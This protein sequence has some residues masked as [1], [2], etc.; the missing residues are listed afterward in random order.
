MECDYQVYLYLTSTSI[1]K[2]QAT[3]WGL[4]LGGCVC[5]L[6]DVLIVKLCLCGAPPTSNEN[7]VKKEEVD[8]R[9][10]ARMGTTQTY[11]RV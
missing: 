4:L 7:E 6:V 3:F 11:S 10:M 2:V 8:V 1:F 5:I 9:E